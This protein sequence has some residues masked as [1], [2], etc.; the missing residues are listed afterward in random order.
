MP[1]NISDIADNPSLLTY[2]IS[3]PD[4]EMA[5]FR[6]LEPQDV[7]V[8]A[9]FFK[10]LSSETRKYYIMESYDIKMARELCA[11]INRYDKLRFV[12]EHNILKKL[13]ALFEFS[14]DIPINDKQRFI[15]YDIRL[16]STDCRMGPCLADE[17][18]NQGIGSI[19]LPYLIDIAK[20]FGKKRM[21]LWGGVFAENKRAI[22]FYEKYDFKKLGRFISDNGRE[23]WDMIRNT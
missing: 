3:L 9:Q 13:I 19:I 4:T 23:S 20:K 5:T 18:Q 10:N 21:I 12:L 1:L 11:A 2:K 17:Y 7:E 16:D 14:F 6:P 15:K 22:N 8:L